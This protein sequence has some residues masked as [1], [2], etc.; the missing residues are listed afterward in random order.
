MDGIESQHEDARADLV[1]VAE[2][3]ER[4]R[5]SRMTVYRLI[6]SGELPALRMG[7]SFRVPRVAVDEYV[8]QSFSGYD[9]D[10]ESRAV[11]G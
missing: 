3:A 5:L 11:N 2:V 7:R 4:L 6:H 8:E 10:D 9:F 1:T